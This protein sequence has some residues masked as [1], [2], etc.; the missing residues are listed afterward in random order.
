MTPDDIEY[1]G[2]VV[3]TTQAIDHLI[4]SRFGNWRTTGVDQYKLSDYTMTVSL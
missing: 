1:H 2:S 3:H 4:G